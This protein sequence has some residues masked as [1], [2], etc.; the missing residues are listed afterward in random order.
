MFDLEKDPQELDNLAGTP[1]AA[2]VEADMHKRLLSMIIRLQERP[3]TSGK[4]ED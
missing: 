2:E 3:D 1:G 4:S